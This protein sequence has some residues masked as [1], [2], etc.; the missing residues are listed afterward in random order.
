MPRILIVDDN[1]ALRVALKKIL[2]D[3]GGWIVCG[4]AA[5]GAEAVELAVK[6]H[7][8]VVLLDFQMPVMNGLDAAKA[9]LKRDASLPIA[10]YTLHQNS[11]LE[12][13]AHSIGV[14]KV[15][16][17]ADIFSKLVTSLEDLLQGVSE[18]SQP[19]PSIHSC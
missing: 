19:S 9:I 12:S 7:P 14:Q 6:L 10:M 2:L 15:I 11:F 16:C 18:P 4:E 13:H 8:D 5:N 1:Q 3:A 17:K